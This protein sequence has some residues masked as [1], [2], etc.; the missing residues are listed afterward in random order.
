M[1]IV[2]KDMYFTTMTFATKTMKIWLEGYSL[3]Y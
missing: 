2:T 3:A 1:I